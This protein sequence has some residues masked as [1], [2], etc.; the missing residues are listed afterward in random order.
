MNKFVKSC[1]KELQS[2]TKTGKNYN[3]KITHSVLAQAKQESDNT[4]NEA[5]NAKEISIL[6]FDAMST[7]DK[8]QGKFY[9]L[10]KVYK[11]FKEPDLPP[12]K[13]IISDCGSIAE[14]ISLSVDHHSKDL[15][16]EILSYLQDN[17]HL[18]G[19]LETL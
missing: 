16:Q 7:K 18:L 10:F 4:L 9:Q 13:P 14:N 15:V 17:P 2:T 8:K 3:K 19:E 5:L 6:E 1:Q 12:G 11:E